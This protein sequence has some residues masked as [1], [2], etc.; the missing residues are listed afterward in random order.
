MSSQKF[1]PASSMV[2]LLFLFFAGNIFAVDVTVTGV[3]A[4]TASNIKGNV[5][6]DIDWYLEKILG[7]DT[8]KGFRQFANANLNAGQGMNADYANNF[9]YF[10]LG[11][12]ASVAVPVSLLYNYFMGNGFKNYAGAAHINLQAGLNM[13]FTKV[14]ILEDMKFYAN[15]F[16]MDI[17]S[18]LKSLNSEITKARVT[19]IGF[20]VSYPILKGKDFGQP[21]VF[22]FNGIQVGGG[23]TYK[24]NR[25]AYAATAEY[26]GQDIPI[27]V[28]FNNWLITFPLEIYGSMRILYVVSLYAGLGLDLNFG[29]AKLTM[30][31]T[32][33]TY[34]GDEYNISVDFGK[35]VM[36]HIMDIR[37]FLG[38]QFNMGPGH[39][40]VTA[41]I[42]STTSIEATA[43]LRVAM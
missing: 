37:G 8:K 2:I 23:F 25:L 19:S 16:T 11:A 26:S 40:F 3:D 4:S 15:L 33:F 39:I 43:G 35:G 21:Y 36:P 41:S 12:G 30:E 29:A 6:S 20:F 24:D 1:F 17:A 18:L 32:T 14:P 38:I 9:E 10:S 5:E 7:S 34:S 13:K 27:N 42:S 31:D 22:K 28:K